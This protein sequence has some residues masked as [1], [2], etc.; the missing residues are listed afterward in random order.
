MIVGVVGVLVWELMTSK[1]DFENKANC[2]L[3]NQKNFK[4]SQT[5]IEFYTL[6]MALECCVE[7][8]AL[9]LTADNVSLQVFSEI[10][11]NL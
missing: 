6:F 3:A 9:V 1:K 7:G 5:K 10:L 8:Q 4:R 2:E 11:F